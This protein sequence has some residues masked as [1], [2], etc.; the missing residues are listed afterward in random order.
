MAGNQFLTWLEFDAREF[1]PG[2]CGTRARQATPNLFSS[3]VLSFF[4]RSLKFS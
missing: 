2:G 4:L 3:S 1:E